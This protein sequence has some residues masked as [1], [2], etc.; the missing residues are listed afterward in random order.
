VRYALDSNKILKKLKW[1]T[2]VNFKKGLE[3]T[4]LWY[5]DNKKY[6]KS[7]SKNDI[8]KRVGKI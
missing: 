5:L 2:A 8:L 7:I 3:Q 1:K 4:F 6:F